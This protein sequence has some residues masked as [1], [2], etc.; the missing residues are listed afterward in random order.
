MS[1]NIISTIDQTR[2]WPPVL[3]GLLLLLS[4]FLVWTVFSL[5]PVLGHDASSR[6]REAWDT[7]PF[8]YA[9]VTAIMLAQAVAGVLMGGGLLQQPLWSLGGMFVA[10]IAMHPAGAGYNLLPLALILVGGPAYLLLLL[11]AAIGR[12]VGDRLQD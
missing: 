12:K 2:R 4:G 3:I 9:G 10:I 8:W 7:A 1:T 6:I 11:A 5:L